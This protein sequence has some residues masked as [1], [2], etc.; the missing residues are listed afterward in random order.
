MIRVL[1]ADDQTLVRDGFRSIIEREDDIEVVGEAADGLKAVERARKLRPDVVLMDIRMPN[2]DGLEA[3][4]RLLADPSPPRIL[5]LTT[6]DL[7]EYVYAAL[8]AGASGFLLKDVRSGELTEA[9]RTIA[10]GDSLLSPAITARLIEQYVRL[11]PPGQLPAVLA[12][13]TERELDVLKLLARGLSNTEI[14]DQLYLGTSTIKTHVNRVLT[15]LGCRDRAQALVVAY[16]S[17]LV[18][19]GGASPTHD[20]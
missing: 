5:I 1:L 9:I 10:S 19:P 20:A 15:K 3:A 13:L 12:D 4:R 7:D 8:T 14:A 18:R 6:F 2:L 16:E 11:P 17:G